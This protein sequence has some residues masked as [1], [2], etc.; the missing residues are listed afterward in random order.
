MKPTS[1]FF[2]IDHATRDA[3]KITLLTLNTNTKSQKTTPIF[4]SLKS[5]QVTFRQ[6]GSQCHAQGLLVYYEFLKLNS[7]A[8][9]TRI[10]LILYLD[11][12]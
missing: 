9:V 6:N 12:K 5:Q 2:S 11:I 1:L 3:H 4:C 8:L 10:S 7:L